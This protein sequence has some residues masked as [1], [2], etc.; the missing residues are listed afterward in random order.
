MAP[1]TLAAS[2]M[3]MFITLSKVVGSDNRTRNQYNDSDED[4]VSAAIPTTFVVIATD[5]IRCYNA[6]KNNAPGA[7]ITFKDGGGF[8]VLQT[9][10]LIKAAIGIDAPFVEIPTTAVAAEAGAETAEA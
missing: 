4:V 7:R 10:E 8:A 6:R 5:S 2:P 9:V 3:P 1:R